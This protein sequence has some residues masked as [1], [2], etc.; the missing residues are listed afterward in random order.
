[1]PTKEW[2]RTLEMRPGTFYP[3]RARLEQLE[4]V[5]RSEEGQ[6]SRWELTA[7]GRATVAALADQRALTV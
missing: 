6:K 7:D 1:M 4:L 3:A 2:M 5:S